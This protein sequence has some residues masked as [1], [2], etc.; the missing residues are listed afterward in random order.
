MDI[1]LLFV[2]AVLAIAIYLLPTYMATLRHH[3]QAT[4]ILMVNLFLGWSLVGW[5]AAL[6]WAMTAVRP[7]LSKEMTKQCP[8][9]AETIMK[10]AKV[11]RYCGKDLAAG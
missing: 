7:K 4:A 1:V 10:A 6:I 11:C 3:H 5:I 8:A 9:C 2:L